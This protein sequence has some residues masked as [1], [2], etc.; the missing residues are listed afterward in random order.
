MSQRPHCSLQELE[1]HT[2]STQKPEVQALL[3]PHELPVESFGLH[4]PFEQ[5]L[6]LEQWVSL[7]QLV[8]HAPLT[9]A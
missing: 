4:C 2:P 6:P 1:Q 5:K 7:L 9:Q 8:W 3:D